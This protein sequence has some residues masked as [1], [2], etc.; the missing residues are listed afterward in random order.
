MRPVALVVA[1]VLFAGSVW[2]F[3]ASGGYVFLAEQFEV[4]DARQF[5][6]VSSLWPNTE[7][8]SEVD[9]GKLYLYL[10]LY[11]VS[12]GD[13][14]VL[15]VLALGLPGALAY[16]SAAAFL[17]RFSRWGWLLALLYVFNPLFINQPRDVQFRFEYALFPTALHLLLGASEGRLTASLGLALVLSMA[18]YRFYAVFGAAAL[19]LLAWRLRGGVRWGH[20]A[21]ALATGAVL[22]LPR[23]LPAVIHMAGAGSLALATFGVTAY[24]HRVDVFSA[25]VLRYYYPGDLFEKVTAG[26]LDYGF[27]PV[28]LSFAIVLARRGRDWVV[29]LGAVF[30]AVGVLLT[31]TVNVDFLLGVVPVLGRLLRQPYWN[32][33]VTLLGYLIVLT[34]LERR[35]AVLA[36]L[37]VPVLFYGPVY[38]SGDM[39]GYWCAST[40]PRAY[41]DLPGYVGKALWLPGMGDFRAVWVACGRPGW[42]SDV[43]GPT[44]MVEVRSW[45]GPALSLTYT[46]LLSQYFAFFN[47]LNYTAF[48]FALVSV[49][50]RVAYGVV[51]VDY[52][53]IVRDRVWAGAYSDLGRALGDAAAYFSHVGEAVVSSEAL[54]VYKIADAPLC[55]VGEPLVLS[56][57]YPAVAVLY[58]VLGWRTPPV[59]FGYVNASAVQGADLLPGRVAAVATFREMR[60][61]GLAGGTGI[62]YDVFYRELKRRGGLW[63]FDPVDVFVYGEGGRVV[64]S[65]EL[66]A[67]IYD[68]YVRGLVSNVSGVLELRLGGEVFVVSM[69]S[70]ESRFRWVYA[71][72]LSWRGGAVPVEAVF[73]GGLV[74]V[75]ELAFVEPGESPPPRV[76]IITPYDLP[77]P[78]YRDLSS[79]LGVAAGFSGFLRVPG[80]GEYVVFLRVEGGPVLGREGVVGNGSVVRGGEVLDFVKTRVSYVLFISRDFWERLWVRN[81]S[82]VGRFSVGRGFLQ[83]NV[84]YDPFWVLDCGGR[85]YRPVK[86]FGLVNGY[87]VD[88]G[89]VCELRYVLSDVQRIAVVASAG[90]VFILSVCLAAWRVGLCRWLSRRGTPRR[91]LD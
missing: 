8:F 56:G 64:G 62:I 72:R 9:L 86:A 80:E 85:E 16:L 19:L 74:A 73:S 51:G 90:Y 44:G 35:G 22:S 15:Q 47:Y 14:K 54:A 1:L 39:W 68:V 45:G 48:P 11:G 41:W 36:V 30:V 77:G 59:V 5:L 26:V 60:V 10:L 88:V 29:L 84:L 18:S 43:W 32:G 83:F 71:G 24:F 25:L 66:P 38:F 53:G 57:G 87:F 4:L 65:V 20:M 55:R 75:G 40:P 13:Y 2:R 34:R 67:G 61:E 76:F 12:L 78:K 21:L 28:V 82:C 31:S 17:G 91:R 37:A 7:I 46:G 63:S 33:V 3:S 42:A 6:D 70:G 89:G 50:P 79:P 49:D 81:V 27:A 52:V 23:T 58:S 69:R